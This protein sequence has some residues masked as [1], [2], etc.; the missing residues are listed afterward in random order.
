MEDFDKTLNNY[1]TVYKVPLAPGSLDVNI[2]YFP[3]LGEEPRLLPG[4]HAQI[5]NDLEMLVNGQPARIKR[6]VIVGDAVTPG[7]STHTSEIKVL[8][9]LEKN[10]M[11]VEIQGIAAEELLKQ[12]NALSKRCAVGTTR[13]IRY[14]ITVRDLDED[15]LKKH[16]GVYDIP[17]F[18]SFSWI[19]LPAGLSKDQPYVRN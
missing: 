4:V 5:V 11:D 13:P 15:E 1:L 6:Y 18:S 16:E 19:K 10:L 14:V 12:A 7:K 17:S 9:I 8:V 3:E 2:F